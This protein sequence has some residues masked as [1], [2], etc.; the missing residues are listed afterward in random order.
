MFAPSA[1]CGWPHRDTTPRLPRSGRMG[2]TVLIVDDHPSFR[3]SARAMLEAGGLRRRGRGRGRS[4]RARRRRRA[5]PGRRAPRRPAPRHDRVSTSA[6]RSAAATA[7]VPRH[8]ARLE[9]RPRRLRRARLERRARAGS[10][11]RP[12]SRATPSP[13]SSLEPRSRF[14]SSSSRSRAGA[15]LRDALASA[16]AGRGAHRPLLARSRQGTRAGGGWVG[17]AGPRRT[18]SRNRVPVV[19]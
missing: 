10:S 9:P 4:V 2:R 14:R 1:Q 18:R 16:S 15:P 13:R 7:R 6:R 8:R 3:A 19:P 11:P 5:R 17:P 12:S